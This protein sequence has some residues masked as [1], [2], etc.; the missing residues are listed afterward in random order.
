MTRESPVGENRA[1]LCPQLPAK[2]TD[3]HISYHTAPRGAAWRPA[4]QTCLE[5][6]IPVQGLRTSDKVTQTRGEELPV[7][8]GGPWHLAAL[9]QDG[10]LRSPLP[11]H[12]QARVKAELGT[13]LLRKV[14]QN[15]RT[16]PV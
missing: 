15:L 2:G 8:G 3:R 4:G 5:E 13:H 6:L 16:N 14:G 1:H 11:M 9:Q 10:G 12:P 7:R